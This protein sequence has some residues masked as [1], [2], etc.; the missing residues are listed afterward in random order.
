M[1]SLKLT[2][3]RLIKLASRKRLIIKVT[4]MVLVEIIREV[5]YEVK[6][7]GEYA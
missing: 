1:V 6:C 2:S 5:T 7:N 3:L 4:N